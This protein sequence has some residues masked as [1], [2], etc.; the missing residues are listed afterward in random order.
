MRRRFE[1]ENWITQQQEKMSTRGQS[2]LNRL[3]LVDNK[4]FRGDFYA[5]RIQ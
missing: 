2:S 4:L 5:R 1:N 3:M